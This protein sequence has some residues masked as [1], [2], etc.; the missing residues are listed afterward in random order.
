[1]IV[2]SVIDGV[3]MIELPFG[4]ETFEAIVDT[5]F[6]GYLELPSSQFDQLNPEFE[7]EVTAELAGGITITEAVYRVEI[8]FEGRNVDAIVSFVDGDGVLLGTAML[9]DYRLSIDFPAGTLLLE[10]VET[11]P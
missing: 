2:G 3:P 4:P 7:G 9:E 10:R 1:M 11:T 5:G 6:N 8:P